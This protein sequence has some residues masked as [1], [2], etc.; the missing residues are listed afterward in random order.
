MSTHKKIDIICVVCIIIGLVITALFSFGESLGIEV[1]HDEDTERNEDTQYFSAKDSD[2]DWDETAASRIT[3]SED[4]ISIAGSG[5]Y[6]LGGNVYISSAG[7]Y[8]ISG[9]FSGSVIVD[10]HKNSKVWILLDSVTIR[11]EGTAAFIVEQAD[12]VFLTLSDGSENTFEIT[13]SFSA[14]EQESGINAALYSKDDLT[15]N[16]YGTLTIIN[17]YGHGIKAKDDFVMT[18][19]TVNITASEDGINANDSIRIKSSALNIVCG[20]DG[21]DQDNNGGYI[22]LES[23]T[24]NITADDK[25]IYSEGDITIAGGTVN[26]SSEDEGVFAEGYITIDEDNAVVVGNSDGGA[27]EIRAE[28]KASSDEEIQTD[29]AQSS[30]GSEGWWIAAAISAG[31]LL[32]GLV[33]VIIFKEKLK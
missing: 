11:T 18:G 24:V 13:A 31:A 19:G 10:A 29:A 12:K 21:L 2:P 22:Y 23:G 16:G 9:S 1:V 32:A 30:I 20:N 25:G 4:E 14:E 26:I 28:E 3:L 8:V 33:F 7:Y 17:D 15:I 27:L 6:A 5:A